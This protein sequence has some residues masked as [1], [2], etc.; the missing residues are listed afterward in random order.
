[1]ITSS[2]QRID[3][4]TARGWWGNDT[5]HSL[6]A[7][8][9]A[10]YPDRTAVA[11]QPNRDQLTGTAA[12]RLTYTELNIASDNLAELLLTE[13]VDL[14]DKLIV[15][16]PNIAELVVTYHAASKIGAV[17]SPVPVQYGT[18]ELESIR[19]I[20]NAQTMISISQLRGKPLAENATELDLK[21]LSFGNDKPAKATAISLN[22]LATH[23]NVL[24]Q[25]QQQH[26]DAINNAN[27]IVSICWT[28]G[29]TGTPK[30]VPRSHNMWLSTTKAEIDACDYRNGDIL[31]NPFPLVNMAAIGAFLFP[32]VY[33][34]SSLHLHHPLDPAVFLQQLQ[35]EKITFTIAP[36]ALLNQLA[37]SPEMWNQFD[38]SALRRI[39]S[40]SAPLAPSMVK[41]FSEQYGKE[42]IN[43]YGSNEGICLLSTDETSPE[44]EQRATMFPRLGAVEIPWR[45]TVYDFAKTKV[46]DPTTGE[47]ITEP[48]VAGELLI[49]G[50]TIFDGYFHSD[51]DNDNSSHDD[52][53][54]DDGYFRTGDLVEICGE[55]ALYYQIVGRC[56]DI[57]NR[58]GMKISPAE[59]DRLLEGYPD[60]KEIAV[61]AY[62]DERLNEKV[63]ACVVPLDG[64]EPPTL[65][66]LVDYLVEKDVAMYKLPE[67][68][69]IFSQLPRNPMNKILRFQLQEIVSNKI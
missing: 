23:N 54:S 67:R 5:L 25:H 29:T 38:F 4:Y 7:T 62:P 11:D 17:V 28:S 46:A 36:P 69:E 18:Y 12:Q 65:Q 68:I 59:I 24:A 58:G 32:S 66:Q 9:A 19:K 43:F 47:E 13:G 37:Q 21:V 26:R 60:Q 39:G 63:C 52:V 41:T 49:T 1:M 48:G 42:I 51:N 55:P 35:Q 50:P 3:D 27:S 33:M 2:Q 10:E 22:T 20:L 57:I 56:K 14:E 30:G 34:A 44:P 16:L 31:L 64:K 8:A 45:G 53:F 61:C 6:L 40:G 15:Q